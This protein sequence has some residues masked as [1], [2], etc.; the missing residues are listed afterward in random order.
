MK[1]KHSISFL[2]DKSGLKKLK[3]I[4]RSVFQNR[5]YYVVR[6]KF[7]GMSLS[8]PSNLIES[9]LE[10]RPTMKKPP[11][12]ERLGGFFYNYKILILSV[13]LFSTLN[14][15]SNLRCSFVIF[16]RQNFIQH[17][18]QVFNRIT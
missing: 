5:L 10:N 11:N 8:L 13:T 7:E 6:H 9:V 4:Y 1:I 14:F 17:F 18:I 2:I 15:I 3:G 12:L 16:I